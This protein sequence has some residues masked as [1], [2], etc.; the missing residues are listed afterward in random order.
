[1]HQEK[2]DETITLHSRLWQIRRRRPQRDPRHDRGLRFL[3]R[4]QGH[5]EGESLLRPLRRQRLLRQLR[6]SPLRPTGTGCILLHPT[7]C[8]PPETRSSP[9]T[10][11]STFSWK[12]PIART[13]E[14]S[15]ALVRTAENAGVR[16]MVAENYRFLH[17]TRRAKSMIENRHARQHRR[18]APHRH[19][20]GSLSSSPDPLA[21]RRLPHRRRLLHRRRHTLH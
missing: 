9:Q 21:L 20:G 10:T 14:E 4:Q 3:L 13:I 15:Q 8:T 1:M 5:F 18:P 16:L 12:K 6:G 2:T 11:A 7:P 19:Q 17:T